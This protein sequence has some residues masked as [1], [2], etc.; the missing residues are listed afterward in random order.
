M[1]LHLLTSLILVFG[2]IQLIW[3]KPEQQQQIIQ[4]TTGTAINALGNIDLTIVQQATDYQDLKQK[5]DQ[6]KRNIQKLPNDP[7]FLKELQ[8]AEKNLTDFIEG[9]RK[10]LADIDKI[11]LNN[12]RG[13]RAKAYFEKGK[14][15]AAR[16]ALDE[17][18][19][20]DEK[21]ALL[22]KKCKKSQGCL[23]RG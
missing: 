22:K 8:Q 6:A 9:I 20:N 2:C 12:E 23:Q 15:Q 4:N 13:I 14:Y 1:K 7:D 3:A 16:D 10:L 19:M 21:N 5:V 17:K 18:E 11:P